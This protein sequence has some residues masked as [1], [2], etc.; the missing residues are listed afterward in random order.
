MGIAEFCAPVEDRPVQ[1]PRSLAEQLAEILSS[2][3][4][5][6]GLSLRGLASRIESDH[7]FAQPGAHIA[8]TTLRELERGSSNPTLSRVEEMAAAYG[9]ELELRVRKRRR[10]AA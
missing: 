7:P 4:R 8:H 5:S 3:R 10:P 1:T 6:A 2:S 9:L